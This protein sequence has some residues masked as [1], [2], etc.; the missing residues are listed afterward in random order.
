MI[1]KNITINRTIFVFNQVTFLFV[2]E[3]F[4]VIVFLFEIFAPVQ[5]VLKAKSLGVWK[6]FKSLAQVLNFMHVGV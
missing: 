2:L 6:K 5:T 3:P 4:F 1:Y